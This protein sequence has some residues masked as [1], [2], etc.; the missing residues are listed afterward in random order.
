[1]EASMA[2]RHEDSHAF[3][4]FVLVVAMVLTL[5]IAFGLRRLG[6][7]P[8]NYFPYNLRGLFAIGMV[9]FAGVLSLLSKGMTVTLWGGQ[10]YFWKPRVSLDAIPLKYRPQWILGTIILVLSLGA[11][12]LLLLTSGGSTS[13]FSVYLGLFP[14]VISVLA[15]SKRFV[16]F[17]VV[18]T[19]GVYACI[20]FLDDKLRPI[21]GHEV[22]YGIASVLTFAVSLGFTAALILRQI[23]D[24]KGTTSVTT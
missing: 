24:D 17:T 22:P 23:Q 9:S 18:L 14:I 21:S 2:T 20:Y 19:L 8:N 5:S 4:A 11:L 12:C 6:C 1:M 15:S 16:V 7:V 3:Y 13:P 10:D